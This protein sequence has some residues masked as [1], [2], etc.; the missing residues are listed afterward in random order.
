MRFLSKKTLTVILALLCVPVLSGCI[1][2][3]EAIWLNPDGSGRIELAIGVS[4][5]LLALSE[6]TSGGV[7]EIF[8]AELLGLGGNEGSQNPYIKDLESKEYNQDDFKYLAVSSDLTDVEKAFAHGGGNE[9][10]SLTRLENGNMLLKQTFSPN[11]ETEIPSDETSQQMMKTML[12]GYYWHSWST[13]RALSIP[14][15][16]STKMRAQSNGMFPSWTWSRLPSHMK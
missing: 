10:L 12:T 1:K 11:S 4:E 8:G 14:T 13:W 7:E 2:A 6:D 15:G 3:E 9:F 16:W 5:Q